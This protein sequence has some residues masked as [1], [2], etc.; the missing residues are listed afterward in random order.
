[1]CVS[2]PEY[3]IFYSIT[4]WEGFL[5]H[6]GMYVCGILLSSHQNLRSWVLMAGENA[7]GVPCL[8]YSVGLRSGLCTGCSI[9]SRPTFSN[10]VFMD[11][12]LCTWAL[13]CW[14]RFNSEGFFSLSLWVR[15]T[16]LC[17]I[18]QYAHSWAAAAAYVLVGFQIAISLQAEVVSEIVNHANHEISREQVKRWLGVK[19]FI[20]NSMSLS[21]CDLV[22]VFLLK[23]SMRR[24]QVLDTGPGGMK[25]EIE[26]N[27][28]KYI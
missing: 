22:K 1:M 19:V 10:H 24:Y 4:L 6:V 18:F 21:L 5:L 14:N 27:T 7:W 25:G 26:P 17:S 11:F 16:L 3:W 15:P 13:S 2:I 20:A 8:G 12:N 28:L 23:V 9:S